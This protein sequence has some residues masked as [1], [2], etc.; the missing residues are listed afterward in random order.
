[1]GS[2]I[3]QLKDLVD[4][5]P[6]KVASLSGTESL[7]SIYLQKSS[8]AVLQVLQNAVTEKPVA[9]VEPEILQEEKPRS[10]SKRGG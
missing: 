8:G 4:T 3:K 1:M 9:K 6:V 5:V 7:N 2:P 10:R